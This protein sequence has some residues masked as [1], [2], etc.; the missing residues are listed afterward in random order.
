MQAPLRFCPEILETSL[1]H[2]GNQTALPLEEFGERLI[3]FHEYLYYI[4]NKRLK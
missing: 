1:M 3:L 4:E 2:M